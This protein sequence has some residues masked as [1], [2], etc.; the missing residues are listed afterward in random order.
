MALKRENQIPDDIQ[1]EIGI[2]LRKLHA[3]PTWTA[4]KHAV[5]EEFKELIKT[6]KYFSFSADCRDYHLERKGQ[7][8]IYNVPEDQQGALSI[9]AGKRIRLVCDGSFNPYTARTYFA[10]IIT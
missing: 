9:F 1:D 6:E 3:I 8:C 7:S 5:Y 4:H 10:K 2:C